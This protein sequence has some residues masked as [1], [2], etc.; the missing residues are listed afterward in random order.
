[1]KWQ[2]AMIPGFSPDGKPILSVLAKKS[3]TICP[4]GIIP[5]QKQPPL[6][7]SEIYADPAN[8]ITS[9]ILEESDLVPYK[10]N[11]DIVVL[12]NAYSPKGKKAFYLD[13]EIQIGPVQKK[14]RVFGERKLKRGLIR[15]VKFTDPVPY[16]QK[17]LGWNNAY[18]GVAKT[19]DGSLFPYPP[20]PIGRGFYLKGG[21]EKYS[22]ILVPNLEDPQRP[23]QPH[24]LVLRKFNDWKKA[25]KPMSFGW[26]RHKFFPRFTFAG[27]S[28]FTSD[29]SDAIPKLD[30]RFFQGAS[31][32]LCNHL[33]Q[34][35]EHVKLIYMDPQKPIFEFDLP[36]EKPVITFF[37]NNSPV[38]PAP[39]LQTLLINKEN[40]FLFLVWRASI[41]YDLKKSEE[42]GLPKF[43]VI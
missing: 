43:Q 10:Q 21:F 29:S 28:P 38:E 6:N 20:N 11:T 17:E 26:T 34:G 31:E 23:L 1:M 27:A 9:E 16:Q 5:V 15:G 18:G 37:I 8:P 2:T 22:E 14:I 40:S 39:I 30:F 36:N 35:D 19:K 42:S 25:P 32:G 41:Q 33:L 12:S 7:T 24:E 3:Y 4:K 13:C